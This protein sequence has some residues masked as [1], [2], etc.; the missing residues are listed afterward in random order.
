MTTMA[1]L[2]L[3]HVLWVGGMAFA[4]FF[5]RPAVQALDPPQRGR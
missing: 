5:L 3:V 4:H 2:N 1:L